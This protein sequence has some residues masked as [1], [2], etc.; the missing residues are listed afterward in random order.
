ME[1]NGNIIKA[2]K[3]KVLVRIHDGFEMGT[4][5][6]L[7]IDYSTGT[8]RVDLPEYYEEIEKEDINYGLQIN[9]KLLL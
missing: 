6:S 8:P 4:E 7:G 9:E 1:Q 3:G 2:N 5:I